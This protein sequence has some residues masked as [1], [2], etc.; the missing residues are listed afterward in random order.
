MEG[1][2]EEWPT[3]DPWHESNN[4]TVPFA[5]PLAGTADVPAER[6]SVG[7]NDR[8][9]WRERPHGTRVRSCGRKKGT[10]HQSRLSPAPP[11]HGGEAP[12]CVCVCAV[13]AC[14]S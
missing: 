8:G 4:N 9:A 6:L 12:Q 3:V 5:R 10:H 2:L 1:A 13:G 11:N 14:F 7:G